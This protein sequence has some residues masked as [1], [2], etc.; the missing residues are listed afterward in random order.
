MTGS[1]DEQGLAAHGWQINTAF[2]EVRS[3]GRKEAAA[4]G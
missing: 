1:T 3:V 2:I 4:S